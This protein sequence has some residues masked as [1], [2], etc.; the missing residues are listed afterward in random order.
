MPKLDQ[1]RRSFVSHEPAL[2]DDR[3]GLRRAGVAMILR[4]NAGRPEVLFI[5]R[6]RHEGD[7]WSGHMA[8]PGGRMDPADV[9]VQT[10]AEREALEEVGVS[11]EGAE[12]IGRLDDLQGRHA[13]R[14]NQLVISGF[15]FHHPDPGALQPNYEV[16]DC[17]WF[18]L[19]DLED[20]SRHVERAFRETGSMRF[21][22][23]IVGDPDRHV[24]W[25]LTHRFL[26]VF[27]TT[28]GR[29]FPT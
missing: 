1:I 13:G 15:V 4:E 19:A 28:L 3:P 23:V 8:F 7:P 5:E 16:E 21:P 24:V 14:T 25:G 9:S 29:P 26:Q 22:G 27:W 17:F 12:R 11:L 10:A 20:P 18:P 6:A 2:I